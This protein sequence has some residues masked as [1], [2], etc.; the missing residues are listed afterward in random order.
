MAKSGSARLI[1]NFL[2][3]AFLVCTITT[4]RDLFT[5]EGDRNNRIVDKLLI[6][7]LTIVLLNM[8]RESE[9]TSCIRFRG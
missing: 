3:V 9:A 1:Y 7:T 4:I 6:S 8:T 2:D 5:L